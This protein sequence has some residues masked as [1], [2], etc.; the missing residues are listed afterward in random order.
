M[1]TMTDGE[2]KAELT[3]LKGAVTRKRTAAK[4]K[5]TLAEKLAAQEETKLAES[6]L[7]KHKLNY[8]ELTAA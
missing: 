7:H 6:A 8:Y 3:R 4:R 5:S 1:G 2:W